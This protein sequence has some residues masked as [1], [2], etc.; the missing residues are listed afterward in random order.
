MRNICSI[1]QDTKD[2]ISDL[3]KYIYQIVTPRYVLFFYFLPGLLPK[4]VL[5]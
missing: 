4:Y 3:N 1:E 2:V 5:K